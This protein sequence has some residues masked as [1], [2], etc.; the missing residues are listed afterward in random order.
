[1]ADT[2]E[3]VQHCFETV[4]IEE[5][6]SRSTT[7]D[8]VKKTGRSKRQKLTIGLG[9]AVCIIIALGIGVGLGLGLTL[10]DKSK[11]NS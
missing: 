10:G 1:M 6:S 9:I 11:S 7:P 2:T 4:K 3:N 8:I 5:H